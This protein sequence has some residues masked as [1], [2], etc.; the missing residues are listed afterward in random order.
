MV[1]AFGSLFSLRKTM[2]V[3]GDNGGGWSNYE[4]RVKRI[5]ILRVKIGVFFEG[6]RLRSK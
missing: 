1:C 6:L 2:W 4:N 3:D 5:W